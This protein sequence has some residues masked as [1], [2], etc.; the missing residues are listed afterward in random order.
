MSTLQGKTLFIIGATHGKG[1]SIAIT[2]STLNSRDCNGNFFDFEP[3]AV[4]PTVRLLS[5]F[6]L[7]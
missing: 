3:S 6:F 5:D 1:L 2:N 4:D 7:D